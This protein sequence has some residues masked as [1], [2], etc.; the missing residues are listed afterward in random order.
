MHS[1]WESSKSSRLS[2]DSIYSAEIPSSSSVLPSIKEHRSGVAKSEAEATP[3]QK[4]FLISQIHLE[5]FY[6][7]SNS[8]NSFLF[9]F[10]IQMRWIKFAKKCLFGIFPE[11]EHNGCSSGFVLSLSSYIL[12][13]YRSAKNFPRASWRTVEGRA[14]IAIKLKKYRLKVFLECFQLN[15]HC[16]V[17]DGFTIFFVLQAIDTESIYKLFQSLYLINDCS[18]YL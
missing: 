6:M 18:I 13:K 1:M 7:E 10:E 2:I 4:L 5:N 12:N 16:I 14:V 17:L 8:K 15:L 9:I 11:S 3:L